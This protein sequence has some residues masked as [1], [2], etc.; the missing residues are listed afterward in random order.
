[1]SGCSKLTYVN[2]VGAIVA[3]WSGYDGVQVV[4]YRNKVAASDESGV[5]LGY[6]H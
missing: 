5:E 6:F 1:M 2:L 3:T 4:V